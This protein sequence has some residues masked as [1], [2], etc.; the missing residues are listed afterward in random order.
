MVSASLEVVS[1]ILECGQKTVVQSDDEMYLSEV[2]VGVDIK[3]LLMERDDWSW[4]KTVTRA[5]R[6]ARNS[7]RCERETWSGTNRASR[8]TSVCA[9]TGARGKFQRCGT[10]KA[11]LVVLPHL[12]AILLSIHLRHSLMYVQSDHQIIHEREQPM[13][14]KNHPFICALS[15]SICTST[16][17]RSLRYDSKY[18]ILSLASFSSPFQRVM[19]S[20]SRTACSVARSMSR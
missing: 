15:T 9:K 11:S 6:D 19:S 12:F 7:C 10:S 20:C 17:C 8:R 18:A 14:H 13:Q 2:E 1:F 5:S 3:V 16:S 4:G